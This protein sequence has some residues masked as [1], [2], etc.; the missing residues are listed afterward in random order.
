LEVLRE[1]LQKLQS[2]GFRGVVKVT[3]SAGVFCFTGNAADGFAPASASLPLGKCDAVGNPFEDS[4]SGQQHQ[5]LA[6]ANLVSGIR[7]RTQGAITVKV[8][9]D[10]NPRALIPYPPRTELVTAGEWN[11]AAAANNRVDFALEPAA[12]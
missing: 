9:N 6:F 3:S 7:A 12:P 2:Q 10:S 4:L 5:S 11:R 8:D 1:L